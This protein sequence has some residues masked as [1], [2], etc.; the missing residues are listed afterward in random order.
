MI[1]MRS[2]LKIG[3]L[4]IKTDILKLNV[5]FNYYIKY[6]K[7]LCHF[8]EKRKKKNKWWGKSYNTNWIKQLGKKNIL[9]LKPKL[10]IR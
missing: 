9:K 10:D 6:H 1:N 5:C 3:V 2:H 8:D 4:V 7:I